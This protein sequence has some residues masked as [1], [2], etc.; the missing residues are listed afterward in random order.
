MKIIAIGDKSR[1]Q[2]LRSIVLS[3]GVKETS[4]KTE[5]L[6]SNT[7]YV[8]PSN[9]NSNENSFRSNM[10]PLATEIVFPSEIECGQYECCDNDKVILFDEFPFRTQEKIDNL[11]LYAQQV[12]HG[13]CEIVL[14]LNDRK[15]MES[16]ISTE[17]MAFEGA[18]DEYKT[19]GF[20]VYKYVQG[21]LNDFL[22]GMGNSKIDQNVFN[23]KRKIGQVKEEV[24]ILESDYNLEYEINI[25]KF[26]ENPALL[27]SFFEYNKKGLRENANKYFINNAK[28]CF[29]KDIKGQY[30][31]F[32]EKIYM[33][34]IEKICVW[35]LQKDINFLNR[36]V[37][38]RFEQYFQDIPQLSCKEDEKDY[39]I[40][41]NQNI[42]YILSFK[43]KMKAFFETELCQIIKEQ[44]KE[45][46]NKLEE[47]LDEK[48]S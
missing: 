11:N 47:L 2:Y 6:G 7:V 41:I 10:L 9:Y 28:M 37:I 42:Q 35:D 33:R 13:L 44:I 25:H 48:N 27:D 39:V 17:K 43:E 1:Y 8:V 30:V 32:Y 23:L 12:G 26:F 18:Y 5:Y 19:E 36:K 15:L 45:R 46:M 4:F 29:F 34:Y 20:K 16:D 14:I 22:F 3:D 40:W 31:N 24:E 21:E 38:L